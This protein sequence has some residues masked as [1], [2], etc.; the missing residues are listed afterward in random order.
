MKRSI[1]IIRHGEKPPK[2]PPP[3]GVDIN[4]EHNEYS[5]IPE[6]WQRAGALVTFFSGPRA[7]L[8]TPTQLIAPDYSHHPEPCAR[9]H[10]TLQPLAKLPGL[11]VESPFK[12]AQG[13]DLAKVLAAETTGVSLVCWEH[14][15]IIDIARNMPLLPGPEI[16][17]KWP[18]DRFDVV[19]CFGL[20]AESGKYSFTQVPQMLL[21]GDQDSPIPS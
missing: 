6:G 9:T 20:E 16:P 15:A 11:S 3:H 17:G 19:W 4:G 12:K 14:D 13:A 18:A 8:E 5:L 10:E 21:V 2:D 7:V 1:Y